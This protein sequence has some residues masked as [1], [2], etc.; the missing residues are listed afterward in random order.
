VSAAVD[1]TEFTAEVTEAVRRL[2]GVVERTPLQRCARLSEATQAQVW[3]KREDLQVGRSYKV[4]GAYNT[5]NSKPPGE[6]ICHLLGLFERA[7]LLDLEITPT[8]RL[9]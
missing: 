7:R 3:V 2:A 5:I 9:K 6:P 1:T 4:R 8:E